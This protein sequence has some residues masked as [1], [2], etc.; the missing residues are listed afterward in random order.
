MRHMGNGNGTEIIDDKTAERADGWRNVLTGHGVAA[1]DKTQAGYFVVETFTT[2]QAAE[3]WRGDDLAARIVEAHPNEMLREGFDIAVQATEE[4][5]AADEGKDLQEVIAEHWDRLDL[6]E[7]LWLALCYER[8]YGGAGILMGVND[9]QEDLSTPLNLDNV[10]SFDWLTV[11]EPRELQ[12]HRWYADPAAATFGQP[13]IY[14]LCALSPGLAYEPEQNDR[15]LPLTEIH[16]SRIVI[17]PGIKV[18]RFQQTSTSS[19]AGW[20]DS[21]FTRV[22]RVLRDFNIGWGGASV[23]LS[24]FA[25]AVFKMKGLSEIIATDNG[26]MLKERIKAAELSRSTMR[27]LLIDAD[28]E[29][30]ERKQTPISGL[31]EMLDRFATRLAAAADMP[32]T[33]L[34]GQSPTGL[35]ATGESDIRFFYDRIKALQTR[36]VTPAVEKI[37]APLL[38]LDSA[39]APERWSVQHRP[40]WQPTEAERA[41]ARKTQAETD[42]IYISQQVL[43]PDDVARSR[44]G[45]DAYSFETQ[46]DFAERE[47]LEVEEE[48]AAEVAAEKEAAELALRE[49]EVAAAE[50]GTPVPGEEQPPEPD[51]D[52]AEPEEA[53]TPPEG[54]EEAA[55]ADETAE[56]DKEA[57]TPPPP[58]GATEEPDEE[59]EPD[60]EEEG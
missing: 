47:A 51:G 43:S 3:V 56:P 52:P 22:L 16:E 57:P 20:G 17:F 44:F 38:R 15:A 30:F 45:G 6:T 9:G 13:A 29:E 21:I 41:T 40:L 28:G 11:L 24:D 34:F 55:P 27:A 59:P 49:R 33:L 54:E 46:V 18:S 14:Q 31:P 32:V 5:E 50:N 7:A 1:H 35:N 23:L 12:P 39:A 60:E 4:E 26:E 10:I 25:Q 19:L 2:E 58:P 36:K 42:Q 53:E 8:A 37:T 48:A